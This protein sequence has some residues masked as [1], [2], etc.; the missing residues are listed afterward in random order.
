M[1]LTVRT[2]AS[3]NQTAAGASDSVVGRKLA[4]LAIPGRLRVPAFAIIHNHGV[5]AAYP[6]P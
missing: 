3:K 2:S 1:R 5:H 6:S 4:E